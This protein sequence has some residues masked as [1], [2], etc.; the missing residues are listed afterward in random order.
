MK[1]SLNILAILVALIATTACNNNSNNDIEIVNRQ[2]TVCSSYPTAD[3][4]QKPAMSTSV[5]T[6]NANLT[7]GRG[8][9]TTSVML[10]DKLMLNLKITG[11]QFSLSTT[12]NGVYN[13]TQTTATTISSGSFVVT[14]VKGEMIGNMISG[15]IRLSMVVND[16][17]HVYLV[18]PE[19][20]NAY[21]VVTTLDDSTSP[22]ES[23]S[24]YYQFIPDFN[25]GKGTLNV[26]NFR[27][28]TQSVA[29]NLKIEN[30]PFEITN[31]GYHITAEKVD[32]YSNFDITV[33]KQAQAISG[34]FN[35]KDK[36]KVSFNGTV[37]PTT[38]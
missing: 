1:K 34:S 18:S 22:F 9:L 29:S 7:A 16:T 6:I 19:Y 14:D 24:T 4:D 33:T 3:L 27:L 15:E 13:I 35:V 23:T 2:L 37:F 25:T 32:N 36:H 8:D 10:E 30:L 20:L 11:L 38:L 26:A 28:G 5:V 31:D 17:Y 21:T 12:T